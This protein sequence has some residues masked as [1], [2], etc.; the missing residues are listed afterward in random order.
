MGRRLWKG[1][2]ARAG[3][4][5]SRPDEPEQ[6]NRL[7]SGPRLR[8]RRERVHALARRR[9][10]ATGCRSG[11]ALKDSLFGVEDIVA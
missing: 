5:Y 2:V 6:W 4:A 1:Y 10:P 8:L 7:S 9:P 11:L 3:I